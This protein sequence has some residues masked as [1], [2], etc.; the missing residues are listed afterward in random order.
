MSEQTPPMERIRGITLNSTSDGV[1]FSMEPAGGGE[2]TLVPEN[3]NDA[4]DGPNQNR[5]L[6][7]KSLELNLKRGEYYFPDPDEQ[8]RFRNAVDELT[9]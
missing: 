2:V 7:L 8:R 9:D 3:P 1:P 6:S 5:T 4:P